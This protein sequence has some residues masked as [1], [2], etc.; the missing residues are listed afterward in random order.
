[1]NK[2]LLDRLAALEARDAPPWRL[3]IR[4][5]DETDEDARKRAGVRRG[6]FVIVVSRL[7][8]AL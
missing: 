6:E 1:M 8:E 2:W 4:H 3:V 7:D 5:D